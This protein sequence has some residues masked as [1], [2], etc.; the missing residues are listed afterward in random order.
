[1]SI[2]QQEGYAAN[3]IY[4]RTI[5]DGAP[6]LLLHGLMAT[7]AMFD[8]FAELLKDRFLMLIPDLRGH[9]KS[10]SLPGPYDVPALAA[11]LPVVL[12][13]LGVQKCAVLGYSHG[14]AVAQQFAHTQS[15]RV[16]KLMLV[17]TYACNVATPKE[18]VE[19]N[20][21]LTLLRFFSPGAL[22]NLVVQAMK[23][24]RDKGEMGL[25]KEQ[26]RWLRSIMA[27]NG[28]AQMRGAARGLLTFDSRPWLKDICAPTLVVGGTHDSG[29]P[30]H[31]FDM[32]VRGIPNAFG[33]LVERA[34]H[35]LIWTHTRELAG[36]VRAQ[37]GTGS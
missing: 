1:M 32:L 29:V 3:G 21:L 26:A 31:H 28:A 2:E 30:R 33:R 19:A 25:T 6:L 15:A 14:G 24:G 17:C 5:G 9:G 22:A 11:D 8:P 13:E 36:I 7:G 23:P 12:S 35:T 18:R 34:G 20:V 16:E 10:C 27:Q 4:F 37:L